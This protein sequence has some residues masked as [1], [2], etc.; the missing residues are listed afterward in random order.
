MFTVPDLIIA[1]CAGWAENAK[2][3][4]RE[5]PLTDYI[6]RIRS[7]PAFKKAHEIRLAG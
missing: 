3:G 5:G 6:K 7:R 2:M 4:W 1:H